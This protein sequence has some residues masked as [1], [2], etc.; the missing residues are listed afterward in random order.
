MIK[1]I[2]RIHIFVFS[3]NCKPVEQ[4]FYKALLA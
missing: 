1:I 4:I 2:I 3:E